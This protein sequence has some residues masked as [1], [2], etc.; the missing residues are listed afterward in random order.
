MVLTNTRTVPLWCVNFGLILTNASKCFYS[1]RFCFDSK[2]ERVVVL[3]SLSEYHLVITNPEK[4][5]HINGEARLY[6]ITV[7]RNTVSSNIVS[8]ITSCYL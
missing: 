6:Q 8:Y 3:L 4:V 2:I 7:T 5:I 1:V